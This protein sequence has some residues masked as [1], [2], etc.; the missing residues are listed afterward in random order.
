ALNQ[1]NANLSGVGY[2]IY[3]VDPM[4]PMDLVGTRLVSTAVD[5]LIATTW[6]EEM[7]AVRIVNG[8][9]GGFVVFAQSRMENTGNL[10]ELMVVWHDANG[11]LDTNFGFSNGSGGWLGYRQ[12]FASS[13]YEVPDI[14]DV[15][16]TDNGMVWFIGNATSVGDSQTSYIAGVAIDY[17]EVNV[18]DSFFTSGGGLGSNGLNRPLGLSPA[19]NG[20]VDFLYYE[21]EYTRIGLRRYDPS[22]SLR[23]EFGFSGNVVVDTDVSQTAAEN[24]V[25]AAANGTG[26]VIAQADDQALPQYTMSRY[27]LN[28]YDQYA[29]F[30]GVKAFSM[31]TSSNPPQFGDVAVVNGDI[32]LSAFEPGDW[33]VDRLL[34]GETWSVGTDRDSYAQLFDG[35]SDPYNS[36]YTM[37]PDGAGGLYLAGSDSMYG[38][39]LRLSAQ[40]EVDETYGVEGSYT[41][42]NRV[43]RMAVDSA[44]NVVLAYDDAITDSNLARL[45]ANGELQ[46]SVT[47][48]LDLRHLFY[49]D[50]D[51][52]LAVFEDGSNVVVEQLG[53]DLI[54]DASFNNNLG[55]V[56]L[57]NQ[58]LL[59][60]ARDGNR[61]LLLTEYDGL[62]K[63]HAITED[64]LWDAGFG[65]SGVVDIPAVYAPPSSYIDNPLW[66]TVD[67]EGNIYLAVFKY[68]GA[69]EVARLLPD[70][71]TDI[72]WG[73]QGFAPLSSSVGDVAALLHLNDALRVIWQGY[74][75][76]G[77]TRLNEFGFQD[78]EPAAP[79]TTHVGDLFGDFAV[80][81][82]TTSSGASYLLNG[83]PDGDDIVSIFWGL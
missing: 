30:C 66:V 79:S 4:G 27:S 78:F 74:S 83:S 51:V 40:G 5:G 22:G 80:D 38:T 75:G 70:G 63:L 62:L 73:N 41:I 31:Y 61:L 21:G 29:E 76:V 36:I 65:N 45:N 64:G 71:T 32:Y 54:A 68:G 12:F 44:S 72:Q 34:N 6:D 46:T 16:V 52:L 67:S 20:D 8:P 48:T 53:T 1:L 25:V 47:G 58:M 24:S 2:D 43:Y 42:G 11:A 55:K 23:T 82:Q 9:D 33:R 81:L 60:A 77:A 50:T 49:T 28:T 15:V 19:E 35:F 69:P 10:G 37:A 18:T 26:F 39:V 7:R 3:E 14:H 59:S 13:A 17:D 57:A 56:E